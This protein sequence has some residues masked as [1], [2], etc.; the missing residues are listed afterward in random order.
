VIVFESFK[1]D[2]ASQFSRYL[3]ETAGSFDQDTNARASAAKLNKNSY[4]RAFV[5]AF[6][7]ENCEAL[8]PLHSF[9]SSPDPGCSISGDW[10]D[11]L[12]PSLTRNC[13]L[14]LDIYRAEIIDIRSE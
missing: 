8:C 1:T 5:A 6:K 2:R 7:E 3:L 10:L 13:L 12:P 4:S 9:L 11:F 14:L